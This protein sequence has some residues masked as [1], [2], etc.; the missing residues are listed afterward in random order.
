MCLL[1]AYAC[2]LNFTLYQMVMKSCY[3][4]EEDYVE[5]LLGFKDE[6]NL[7]HVFKLTKALYN[8]KQVPRGW[9]ERLSNFLLEKS[10]T[11]GKVDT[12]LFIKS[13]YNDLLIVQIYVDNIIFWYTNKSMCK[14]FAK[15]I[16]GE[17]E[18]SLM[19]ELSFFLGL[20]LRQTWD[21]IFIHQEKYT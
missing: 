13:L 15:M 11:R 5:Q 18:M 3:I 20:Q 14:E 10:F 1:L 7:D 2:H 12:T 9:Y 4:K 8:L 6:G 21:G 19:N 16:Q 17:L